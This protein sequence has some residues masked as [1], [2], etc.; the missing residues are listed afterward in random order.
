M[1]A[2]G[3][4]LEGALHKIDI[5]LGEA[6]RIKLG[7]GLAIL[8]ADTYMLYIKTQNFHWNV[9]GPFFYS[10]HAAFEKQYQDLAE[11]NDMLAERIRSLGFF[12]IASCSQFKSLSAV[13]ESSGIPAA[14]DMVE[15]L[16]KGNE[17]IIRRA[18]ELATQAEEADD[19][20]TA[21]LVTKRLEIHEKAAWMLR[22]ILKS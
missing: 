3:L 9:T 22:S 1:D 5:G 14:P 10:L 4:K 12:A 7:E 13:M 11:A 2:A 6:E 8:L 16:V 18:R 21:D 19:H 15:E 20:G 17:I